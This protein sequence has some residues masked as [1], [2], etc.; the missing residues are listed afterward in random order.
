MV[1]NKMILRELGRLI[2]KGKNLLDKCQQAIVD[3]DLPPQSKD[4]NKEGSS[5]LSIKYKEFPTTVEEFLKKMDES[6]LKMDEALVIID[7]EIQKYNLDES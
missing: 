7:D 4:G 5:Q 6:S 1:Q 2:V 3:K